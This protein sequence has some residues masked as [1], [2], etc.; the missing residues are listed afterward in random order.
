MKRFE[1]DLHIHSVLSPCASL[2]MSPLKIIEAAKNAGLHMIAITD[3]NSTR[4]AE[5][6][7][8]LGAKH[9][10][11]VLMGAEINTREEV[12]CLAFFE[13]IQKLN[14]FQEYLDKKLGFLINDSKL[15]G[16]QLV[17]D[18][19][20][21]ILME[22]DRMLIQALDASI[23]EVYNHVKSLDGLFVPAH[24]TRRSG[25][26]LEQLFM[27]PNDIWV[28][29]LEIN[30]ET[31]YS[32]LIEEHKELREYSFIRS[33]DAHQLADIGSARSYFFMEDLSFSEI[34]MAFAKRD[35]RLI[36]V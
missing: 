14:L 32:K 36:E 2:D 18:E 10:I 28:D 13:T 34:K 12:H 25:G 35:Q 23:D 20:E 22:E 16:Y 7:H 27:I 3:H 15:F 11:F 26:I 21:N 8:T 4:N 31:G 6:T 29:G 30:L 9:G 5:V 1:A 17:V 33:S 24:I 19:E